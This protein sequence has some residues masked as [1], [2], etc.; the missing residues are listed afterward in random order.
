MA[1]NIAE[2]SALIAEAARLGAEF[3]LTPEMTNILETDRERLKGLVRR[4]QDDAS[5]SRFC[6]SGP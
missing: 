5:V 3:V 4:E 6:R 2:A 1:R